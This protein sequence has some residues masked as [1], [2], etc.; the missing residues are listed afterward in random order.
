MQ[1]LMQLCRAVDNK[2]EKLNYL[3]A[4]LCRVAQP[5]LAVQQMYV[6]LTM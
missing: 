3:L 4:A 1:P 5:L 6:N 2:T